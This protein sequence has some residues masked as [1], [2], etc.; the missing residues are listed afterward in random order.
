VQTDDEVR[1]AA[2]RAHEE[3]PDVRAIIQAD[4]LTPW[5]NV[6]HAMDLLKQGGIAK[7]AFGVQRQ[8]PAPS[9]AASPPAVA[10]PKPNAGNAAPP[11]AVA[12][13]KPNAWDCEFPKAADAAGIDDAIVVLMVAVA[14]NGSPEWVQIVSDPGHGF[15]MVAAQCAMARTY[16]PA[17][18]NQGRP[19]AAKTPPIR[20]RFV[21]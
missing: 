15:G 17:R 18:D 5:K 7:V 10:V 8:G 21:R 20:V 6:L 3:A 2:A 12:A 16:S 19:M 1:A 4:S 13:P 9:N 14:A 11:P